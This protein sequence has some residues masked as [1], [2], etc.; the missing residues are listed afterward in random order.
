M[1]ES[2]A[3]ILVGHGSRQPGAYDTLVKLA[4]ALA[5][6]SG[7]PVETAFL[8]FSQPDVSQVVARLA[9][10]GVSNIALLPVFIYRGQHVA[11][12]L[13]ALLAELR[14]RYQG[15]SFSVG[16]PLGPDHRL[17]EIL[18]ERLAPLLEAEASG[19]EI[20]QTSFRII[21]SDAELPAHPGERAVAVRVVHTTGDRRLGRALIF[22][23]GAMAAGIAAIRRG[24]AIV[25]DVGMVKAGINSSYLAQDNRVVSGLD[26]SDETGPAGPTRSAQGIRAALRA[27]PTAIAVVGNA[28]TALREVCRLIDAREISPSLVVGVPVG[29]VGAADA[30]AVLLGK[31]VDHIVLPGTRGGSP[32]AA[33]IV[34]ALGKLASTQSENEGGR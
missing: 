18:N 11:A 7:R 33:A 22:S 3:V 23:P 16:E 31:P 34:N 26:C 12:D 24:E 20:A 27:N 4:A 13:P 19:F 21:E 2:T 1:S 32:V 15:I 5:N 28:P 6:L 25:T 14:P 9:E 30:K 8:Q 29:F 17:A 10:N